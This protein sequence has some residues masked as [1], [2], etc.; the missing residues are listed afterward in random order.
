MRSRPWSSAALNSGVRWWMIGRA[1]SSKTS[2]GTGAGPGV[3]KYFFICGIFDYSKRA[4]N[5]RYVR[6]QTLKKKTKKKAG[7]RGC[8]SP[9][10]DSSRLCRVPV[11]TTWDNGA[12]GQSQGDSRREPVSAR[13]SNGHAP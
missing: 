4:A 2:G 5:S 3:N 1:I 11:L 13:H 6:I 12:D 7:A 8:G 10:P 9:D